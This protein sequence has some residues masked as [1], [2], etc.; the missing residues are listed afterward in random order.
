MLTLKGIKKE[1]TIP[2][3]KN[4]Y[5]S[6]VEMRKIYGLSVKRFADLAHVNATQIREG[7]PSLAIRKKVEYLEKIINLLWKITE[8]NQAQIKEWL[9]R[10]ADEYL[11]LT[12]IDY[13]Q[14]DKDNI[15]NIFH[16]LQQAIYGEVMGA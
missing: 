16:D 15:K 1:Q 14:L 3:Y 8:G 5:L 2:I 9:H 7:E 12:P 13:M 11:G 10:P 4:H 6:L